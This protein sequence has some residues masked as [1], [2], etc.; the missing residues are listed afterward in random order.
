MESV[1]LAGASVRPSPNTPATLEF[2]GLNRLVCG[3]VAAAFRARLWELALVTIE[4]KGPHC[5]KPAHGQ[6]RVIELL[7]GR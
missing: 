6:G 7:T 2:V 3:C 5:N 4:A 1:Q